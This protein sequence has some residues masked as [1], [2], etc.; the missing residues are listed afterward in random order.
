MGKPSAAGFVNAVLRTIS[1]R[2]H[3]L[4]LPPRP[5]DPADREAA[6]EYLSVTLS[7]P[8][9]LVARW[10]ERFGFDATEQWLRFNNLPAP[11]T[12]RA[13]RVKLTPRELAALL[14][15][16]RVRVARR[17]D[18]R[19]RSDDGESGTPGRLRC[20]RPSRGPVAADRCGQR[21]LQRAGR[22]GRSPEAAAIL[23][24]FRLRAGRCAVLRSRHARSRS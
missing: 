22:A 3:A 20:P 21:R 5:V 12:L 11:L 4:P 7:H 18:H 1:R 16:D 15:R 14:E 19:A 8:R 23:R 6:L 10:Y 24:A 9:W 2:R 13:N 17:E